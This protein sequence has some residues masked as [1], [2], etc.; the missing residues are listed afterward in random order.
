MTTWQFNWLDIVLAILILIT[1]GR[2]IW[3]GFIVSVASLIGAIGGFW[4]A[5]H[6]FSFF[7]PKIYPWFQNEIGARIIAFAALFFLVYLACYL[8]GIGVR[9]VLKA[10]WLGWLDRLL[11][12]ILGIAKGVIIAGIVVFILTIFIPQTAPAITNSYIAKQFSDLLKGMTF[13]APDELKGRFLWKW[14]QMQEKSSQSK[15]SI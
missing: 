14:K 8:I 7:A 13:I 9:F 12:C 6:N 5:I 1:V 2:G 4:V 11:G 10:I 15:E 3:T